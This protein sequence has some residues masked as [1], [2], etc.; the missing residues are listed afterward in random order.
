M[1]KAES[2]CLSVRGMCRPGIR[3]KNGKG[4]KMGIRSGKNGWW[5][6]AISILGL[7]LSGCGSGG[8]SGSSSGSSS[9][10]GVQVEADSATTAE[11]R[12]VAV[13]VLGNDS[14]GD[15]GESALDPA[16]VRIA[17]GPQNGSTAIDPQTGEI[18]Y[19]PDPDF[20]GNDSFV[21]TV[22]DM[23]KTSSGS[24]TVNLTVEAVN[25]APSFTVGSD[26]AVFM[27]S[28]PQVVSDWALAI[29]PGAA[30]EIGQNLSFT[31]TNDNKPLFQAQ[32]RVD[33]SGTLRYTPAPGAT[34]TATVS[35]RLADD[36]GVSN[37]GSD[38]SA[39]Q[40][41]Q[42][43]VTEIDNVPVAA[44]DSLAVD[45]DSGDTNLDVLA[46]DGFG[47]DGPGTSAVQVSVSPSQGVATVVVN[48]TTT[49]PTDDSINYR[50]NS[51]FS[52]TDTFEYTIEDADGDV[53]SAVVTVTV[54]PVEDPPAPVQDSLSINE[55]SGTHTIDVLANDSFGPDGPGNTGLAVA[56][57]P[58]NGMVAVQDGGSPGD[59]VD[60][61]LSYEPAANFSG[62]DSFQYAIEDG[63]GDV[64]TATVNVAVNAIDDPPVV[65]GDSLN[66]KE[67]SGPSLVDVLGNDSFGSD[68]AGA[69]AIVLQSQPENGSASVDDGGTPSDPTDDSIVFVP[70]TDFGGSDSF[71]Y[72]IEDSEGDTAAATVSV[73]VEYVDSGSP[74]AN[75]D[76]VRVDVN[77]VT[78]AVNVLTNDDFGPD[79]GSDSTIQVSSPPS[80]GSAGVDPSG[81]PLDPT[82]DQIRYTPD[83]NFVGTDSF[84][85]RIEDSDGSAATA[86]VTVS[87]EAYNS[88]PSFTGGE[89]QTVKGGAG[90][91]TVS[92]WAT[93]ISPG[94]SDEADQ[95]LQ[96]NVT[97]DDKSLFATQPKIDP[98]GTLTYAPA[99]GSIGTATVTVVLKD[100][101]GTTNG[102]DDTSPPETFDITVKPENKIAITFPT[103]GAHVGNPSDISVSGILK[104]SSDGV[105]DLGD[106]NYVEVNFNTAAQS[107][108]D[109]ASWTLT[110]L[111]LGTEEKVNLTAAAQ[112]SSG[113][114]VE[115]T[116]ALET[117][118]LLPN[119][120]GLAVDSINSRA[121]T[122]ANEG[123]V[124]IDLGE[125]S[126]T[127]VS[128][129][130]SGIGS[131]LGVNNGRG[132]AFD[133]DNNRVLIADSSRRA[134]IGVDLATGD[135]T[136]LS[137]AEFSWEGDQVVG[138][139]PGFG[140]PLDVVLGPSGTRAYVLDGGSYA[141]GKEAVFEVDLATGDRSVLSD[142]THG[143]G[144]NFDLPVSMDLDEARSWLVVTDDGQD[145]VFAVDLSTGNRIAIAEITGAHESVAVDAAGD[146][147]LVV[148]DKYRLDSSDDQVVDNIL[149][150]D[151]SAGSVSTLSDPSTNYSGGDGPD[152]KESR[153]LAIDPARGRALLLRKGSSSAN[154]SEVMTVGLS[155]GNRDFLSKLSV[156]SGPELYNLLDVAVDAAGKRLIALRG[157]GE[158]FQVDMLSGNR[159]VVADTNLGTATETDGATDL[160]FD[161]ANGRAFVSTN[162]NDVIMVDLAT[163]NRSVVASDTVGSGEALNE[164]VEMTYEAGRDR[165]LVV[166]TDPVSGYYPNKQRVMVI[167]LAT[168]QRTVL[169]DVGSNIG[170]AIEDARDITIDPGNDRALLTDL[171]LQAL[172]AVDLATGTRSIIS[173]GDSFNTFSVGGVALD[174]KSNRALVIDWSKEKLISVDLSNGAREEVSGGTLGRGVD[175]PT[176]RDIALDPA[177]RRAFVTNGGANGYIFVVNFAP[178]APRDR[179]IFSK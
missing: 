65:V 131:G 133:P 13:D 31:T 2:V 130:D 10:G 149:A 25:D 15:S 51:N 160:A 161:K 86:S 153:S 136:V 171:N 80:Q 35:V 99:A 177:S 111:V 49:D 144:L 73:T 4:R 56:V 83:S 114:L 102:G 108:K 9:S 33:T 77:S 159:S 146:R 166:D 55:D 123:L 154:D 88:E 151:L 110:D 62:T 48:G 157:T 173:S 78:N 141:G 59:P 58:V 87:V 54:N 6:L 43:S 32:P 66:I 70:D 104:G 97:P 162:S 76:A 18:A 1:A 47:G 26:Q 91:Q 143:T 30:N 90:L 134:L 45:E 150:V 8:G 172:M 142:D 158:I 16:S 96:F 147:A 38:Q 178:G 119:P 52:G 105:I 169:S 14:G 112:F 168:K 107:L 21:Y 101:G 120:W 148:M 152:F 69:G 7:A 40:T 137:D 34:G 103:P 117:E 170:T 176:P 57:Q 113:E 11:D 106:M 17:S 81:T 19:S 138:N 84:S 164:P 175:F 5:V 44:D 29:S 63:E 74:T 118:V 93:D 135:R 109:P 129:A 156:G 155:L 71:T 92:G 82:D 115:D 127:V 116:Q 167:D 3:G 22:D 89:D 68:G 179:A 27:G 132:V 85:Y 126:R 12:T 28:G 174:A 20:F 145:A 72:S 46:N 163:G 128:S 67:N 98:A 39:L 64:A 79:G 53:A 23:K 124:E 75:G 24:A 100:D 36:G 165:L 95:T 94:P 122:I 125:G 37:G 139:G 41:F 140:H 42:I 50:P 61:K 121:F 60:D